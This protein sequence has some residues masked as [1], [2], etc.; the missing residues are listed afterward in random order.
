MKA[1]PNSW[2]KLFGGQLAELNE[3]RVASTAGIALHPA[4][5]P[6]RSI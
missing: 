3:Q 1:F 6:L 5:H 2:A 4:L